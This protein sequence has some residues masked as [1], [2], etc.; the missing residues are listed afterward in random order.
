[1]GVSSCLG[2]MHAVVDAT[3]LALLFELAKTTDFAWNRI[4]AMF[5]LYN[6]IAFGGQFALGAIADQRRLYQTM[7]LAGISLLAAAVLTASIHLHVAIVIA[8]IGNVAFHVGAGA[9]VLAIY[10][11]KASAEG[12]FV[13]PGGLGVAIGAFCGTVF[14][15]AW[16]VPALA[17]LIVSG[18]GLWFLGDAGARRTRLRPTAVAVTKAVLMLAAFALLFSIAIRS[19]VGMTMRAIWQGETEVLWA[20][21]VAAFCGKFLGGFLADRFGWIFVSVTAL[22]LSTPLL[23]YE[24]GGMVPAVVGTA[25]FTVT[26]PVTLLAL[27]RA[28]PNEPGLTFGLTTLALL[29]GASPVLMLP[30]D[31]FTSGYV[32]AV[33]GTLSAFALLLG[34]PPLLRGFPNRK[35]QLDL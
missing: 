6:A 22:A 12:V 1:M 28:F 31:W 14:P 16:R 32:V 24:A 35:S 2:L 11:D 27:Y 17:L 7:A 13:A 15:V 23:A 29:F 5:F 34:L 4:W 8:A 33:L 25:L 19:A 30:N 21:A 9:I 26:M 20:L 3:C 18:S 10:P